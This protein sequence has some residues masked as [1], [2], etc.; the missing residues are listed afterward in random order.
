MNAAAPT[1]TQRTLSKIAWCRYVCPQFAIVDQW[2]FYKLIFRS[3]LCARIGIMDGTLALS[4]LRM[5]GFSRSLLI[6]KPHLPSSYAEMICRGCV[7]KHTF[8]AHYTGLAVTYMEKEGERSSRDGTPGGEVEESN[9]DVE[10][11]D[12]GIGEFLSARCG[13]ATFNSY[14]PLDL[15]DSSPKPSAC[16]LSLPAGTPCSMFLPIGWRKQV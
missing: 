5:T 10:T 3:V 1:Q 12:S 8:L 9:P 16:P 15:V 7:K 6:I 13:I 14:H 4:Q 2:H 11:P